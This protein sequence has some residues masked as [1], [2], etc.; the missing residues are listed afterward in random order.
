MDC[1]THSLCYCGDN[2]AI[3]NAMHYRT[4]QLLCG[5][6]HDY[7]HIFSKTKKHKQNIIVMEWITSVTGEF[8]AE[9]ISNAENVSI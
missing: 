6:K 1:V 8:P 4:Q 2:I 7:T 5:K 3:D 9:R